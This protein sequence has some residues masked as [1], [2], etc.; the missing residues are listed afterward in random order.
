M[1]AGCQG[2]LTLEAVYRGTRSHTARPWMGENAVH[3]AAP[4]LAQLAA[5]ESAS[6]VVDGLQFREALQ[7]VRVSA[8]VANNVVPDE[9]RVVVNRR[10]APGRALA[11]A[12]SELRALLDGADE[13][14]VLNASP[15]AP[16]NLSNPL[17]AEFVGTLDL[18]VRPK[19]GWTDVARFAEHGIPALNF[20]PGDP[21]LAH[22]A[23]ERV[24]RADV[25]GCYRVLRHF[26]GI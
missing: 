1:E 18:A 23:G 4:V 24:E 26:L 11:D 12:E 25:E 22:T 9:C 16:P 2:T 10:V 7:V 21:Q 5:Y 14:T 13:I 20:G 15:P 19:F 8:G 17:V 3:A 6:P